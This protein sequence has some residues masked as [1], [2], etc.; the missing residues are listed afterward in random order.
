MFQE[1]IKLL[2]YKTKARSDWLA[3]RD[4]AIVELLAS[5]GLRVS[6]IVSLT[7][8]D[9]DL[10]GRMLRIFGKGQKERLVPMAASAQQSLSSYM[11][12]TRPKLA[13]RQKVALTNV[14]FLS[15]IGR[16]LTTR[17]LQYILKAMEKK[18]NVFLD[19]H[20]HKLRHSFAT[21]LLENGADLRTIQE[22]LGHAS[23]N[24]TQIYTH[25]TTESMQ[26]AYRKPRIH[27]RKKK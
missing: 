11:Q 24:T 5:S 19:L 6:E 18:A 21:N 3:P 17:G 9:V 13:S 14:I 27:E 12:N 2:I 23:I 1:Q 20:P 7:V 22:L 25:V 8:Q 26:A 4:L 16:P 10:K 15:N